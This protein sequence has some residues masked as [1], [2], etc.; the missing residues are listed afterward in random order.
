MTNVVT[1]PYHIAARAVRDHANQNF[2]NGEGW[3]HILEAFTTNE[4]L[5]ELM[6][7]GIEDVDEAIQYFTIQAWRRSK[8]QNAINQIVAT[9]TL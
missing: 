2:M 4:I 5:E 7:E 8:I 1:L 3:D 6:N 9:H